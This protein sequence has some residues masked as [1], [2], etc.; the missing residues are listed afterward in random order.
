MDVN[1]T[2][3][4]MEDSNDG[5]KNLQSTQARAVKQAAKQTQFAFEQINTFQREWQEET[6]Y[7]K[8]PVNS[9]K[10]GQEK[11]HSPQTLIQPPLDH[12]DRQINTRF[13][14][15]QEPNRAT[16]RNQNNNIS[17]TTTTGAKGNIKRRNMPSKATIIPRS[18]TGLEPFK[19]NVRFDMKRPN[20]LLSETI[21]QQ[22]GNMFY[23]AY[24]GPIAV[25]DTN[26]EPLHFVGEVSFR[27]M[28]GEESTIMSAWVTN[29]IEPGVLILGTE[30]MEDIGLQLHDI[31]DTSNPSG[32]AEDTATIKDPRGGAPVTRSGKHRASTP[33]IS[34]TDGRPPDNYLIPFRY[35]FHR[36]VVK[37]VK[38]NSLTIYYH[39]ESG[40]RLRTKKDVDPHIE[41]LP[42]ITRDDFNFTGVILPLDD[43]GN[44]HQS[45]RLA[46]ADRRSVPQ[47]NHQGSY[48]TTDDSAQSAEEARGYRPTKT[49][50]GARKSQYSRR[51]TRPERIRHTGSGRAH[52]E[53]TLNPKN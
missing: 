24:P 12:F 40:I 48:Q 1:D 32:H 23:I 7:G 25:T 53:T 45:I 13:G 49:E 35:K 8:R 30:V 37:A 4:E 16:P 51:P 31:P 50:T 21:Q 36:E 52:I 19:W 20:S 10:T 39:T 5:N 26:G 44:I 18:S 6:R 22:F 2:W 47:I 33:K 9:G 15:I 11:K 27:I 46:H 43:P 17:R 38:G 42:G 29:D 41:Y 28:I 3:K 34:Y 14:F